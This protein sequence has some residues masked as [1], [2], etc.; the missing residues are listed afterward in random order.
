MTDKNRTLKVARV[1]AGLTQLSVAKTL[2]VTPT[3]I[4][5]WETGKKLPRLETAF[6]LA[7]LYGKS[8]DD[9]FGYL[10]KV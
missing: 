6:Q 5:A 2:D 3:T 8:V 9:L 4:W 1:A 7:R 10:I